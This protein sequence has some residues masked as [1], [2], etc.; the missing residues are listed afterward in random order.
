MFGGYLRQPFLIRC[1]HVPTLFL[2]V[3]T[4]SCGC[5]AG[6]TPLSV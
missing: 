6:R 4:V 3:P 5:S 2:S 1:L